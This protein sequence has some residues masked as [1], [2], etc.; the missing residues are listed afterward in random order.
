[1]L[2]AYPNFSS[3]EEIDN[4]PL[5][6]YFLYVMCMYNFISLNHGID[7]ENPPKE[8]G[9]ENKTRKLGGIAA[10]TELKKLAAIKAQ[11]EVKESNG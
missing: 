6:D 7:P 5:P 1:M 9:Q 8:G 11:A 4:L 10:V 2:Q 3:L